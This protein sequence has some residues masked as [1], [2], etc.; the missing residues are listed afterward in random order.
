MS[1]IFSLLVC[2]LRRGDPRG[3]PPASALV[4]P[5]GRGQAIAPT[6]DAASGLLNGG[7]SRAVDTKQGRSN[8]QEDGGSELA[9]DEEECIVPG[10]PIVR[11]STPKPPSFGLGVGLSTKGQAGQSMF[12]VEA[13]LAPP[14]PEE[15]VGSGSGSLITVG[16]TPLPLSGKDVPLEDALTEFL[17]LFEYG[18]EMDTAVLNSPE[19]LDGLA[20]LYGPAVLKGYEITFDVVR[21]LSD[22]VVARILA[23]RLRGAEVW[24]VL[25]RV[26]RRCVEA[27]GEEAALLDTVHAATP[28]H[29]LFE[30]LEVVVYDA[31]RMRDIECITYIASD[32]ARNAF[33][34]LSRDKQVP[35]PSYVAR[36]LESA[37][38]QRLPGSYLDELT[39]LTAVE[40]APQ[41]VPTLPSDR[42]VEQNTEPLPV[43]NDTNRTKAPIQAPM[44]TPIPPDVVLQQMSPE[45][46][47]RRVGLV[48]FAGYLLLLLLAVFA[49]AVVQGLGFASAYLTSHFTLLGI[50]W[51][52]LVYGLLGGCLS[53][54][55]WLGKRAGARPPGFVLVTWFARPLIGAALAVLAFLLLNSGVFVFNGDNAQHGT[56]YALVAVLAGASEW[57]FFRKV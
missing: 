49:L 52:M 1:I 43:V 46:S 24:G 53:S 23:S 16:A 47:E 51:F 4:F 26:P 30:R 14:L 42:S 56:L 5:R 35:E 32:M 40:K 31:Y 48:I 12:P 22:G 37:R 10:V 33:H 45:R 19:G 9:Q 18:V 7:G 34:L 36:L 29:G 13:P 54:I 17:W 38:K 6:Q 8:E 21:S 15:D 57:L 39:L 20:L 27:Q 41:R 2:I 50:P 3:R 11:S 28:P 55:I 25:Y 44:Q